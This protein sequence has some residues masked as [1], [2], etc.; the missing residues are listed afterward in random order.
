MWW[1][2]SQNWKWEREGSQ[3]K[4]LKV[5]FLLGPGWYFLLLSSYFLLSSLCFTLFLGL[6]Y[7][8]AVPSLYGGNCV[9]SELAGPIYSGN[10]VGHFCSEKDC[11]SLFPAGSSL[12]SETIFEESVF[13][14]FA[15]KLRVKTLAAFSWIELGS[16]LETI[17]EENALPLSK[18]IP[19]WLVF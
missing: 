10:N 19:A 5:K 7:H 8:G 11:Y 16:P 3:Y 14:I 2:G 15:K 4:S 1:Q 9:K 12:L 18:P 13:P 6:D 17:F